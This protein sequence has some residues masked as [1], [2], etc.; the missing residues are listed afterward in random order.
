MLLIQHWNFRI[1]PQAE[2]P[3]CADLRPIHRRRRPRFL[4]TVLEDMVLDPH[5]IFDLELRREEHLGPYFFSHDKN[6]RYTELRK[7]DPDKY[8][9]RLR[10]FDLEDKIQSEIV[11]VNN[12]CFYIQ[13]TVK[14]RSILQISPRDGKLAIW[15]DKIC[16][17]H[18]IHI[19]DPDSVSPEDREDEQDY[20]SA[21][22]ELV[23][24]ESDRW[25][26]YMYTMLP[27]S[28]YI[29]IIAMVERLLKMICGYC[30]NH[31]AFQ[32][33]YPPQRKGSEI[34]SRVEFLKGNLGLSFEFDQKEDELINNF[35]KLRNDFAHARWEEIR[36]HMSK[37]SLN[38]G[39]YI[40]A[41]IISK[42][43]DALNSH[44]DRMP[45]T[46][47]NVMQ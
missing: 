28:I 18:D 42:I 7:S 37:F 26:H 20:A 32:A 17:I 45:T 31:N 23:D 2:V 33:S 44:L 15:V 24:L 1:W 5:A 16:D 19:P 12:Y 21:F 25:E 22:N 11:A 9:L 43:L 14:E 47:R 30:E 39:F 36:E 40:S 34:R 4:C 38:S 13:E 3:K 29:I 27:G 35:S 8:G 46:D 10:I 41:S 6:A